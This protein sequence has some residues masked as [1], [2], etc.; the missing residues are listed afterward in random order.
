MT[1]HTPGPWTVE[2]D[3]KQWGDSV[4]TQAGVYV[5]QTHGRQIARTTLPTNEEEYANAHLIAESPGLLDSLQ[6]IMG[7]IESGWLVRNITHDDDP[8]WAMKQIAPVKELKRAQE[9]ISRAT[10]KGPQ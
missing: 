9:T 8:L 1:A 3:S 4:S 7:L 2:E 10:G 6:A 5:I